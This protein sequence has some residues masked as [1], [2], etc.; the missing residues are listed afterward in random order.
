LVKLLDLL[1]GINLAVHTPQIA[2]TVSASIPASIAEQISASNFCCLENPLLD[3]DL[4]LCA[5]YSL[6]FDFNSIFFCLALSFAFSNLV[7]IVG[8]FLLS[9]SGYHYC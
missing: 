5:I 3:E 4:L 7:V 8:S 1:L 6:L 2:D 9:F